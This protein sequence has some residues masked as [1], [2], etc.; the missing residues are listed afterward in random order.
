MI[1]QN[2]QTFGFILGMMKAEVTIN[3]RFVTSRELHPR[4]WVES[5][6]VAMFPFDLSRESY[7]GIMEYLEKGKYDTF[8]CSDGDVFTYPEPTDFQVCV[9][10]LLIRKG[11]PLQYVP[12]FR[13]YPYLQWANLPL[14]KG[15]LFFSVQRTKELME[16]IRKYNS[17]QNAIR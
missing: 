10:K 13:N 4:I 9:M 1:T 5:K 16:Y 11:Y 14:L 6:G 7:K 2:K 3:V 17:T 12:I 8:E 15:N